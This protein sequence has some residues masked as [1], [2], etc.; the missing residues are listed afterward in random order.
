MT[1]AISAIA[2]VSGIALIFGDRLVPWVSSLAKPKATTSRQEAFDAAETLIGYFQ[3]VKE[4]AAEEAARIAARW[5]FAET[6][7]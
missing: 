1:I 7:K 3:S 5:L 2:A 4:P 6:P